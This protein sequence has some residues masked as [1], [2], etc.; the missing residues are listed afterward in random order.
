MSQPGE[1]REGSSK[2]GFP[3]KAAAKWAAGAIVVTAV[4]GGALAAAR[5]WP[6]NCQDKTLTSDNKEKPNALKA[7]EGRKGVDENGTPLKM[8]KAAMMKLAASE[9]ALP[10]DIRGD[11]VGEGQKLRDRDMAERE[12]RERDQL[13]GIERRP[14]FVNV[15]EPLM[16]DDYI[17]SPSRTAFVIMQSDGALALY[18]GSDPRDTN[19]R[20]Q[21]T[22]GPQVPSKGHPFFAMLGKDGNLCI[23]QG[24]ADAHGPSVWC[25]NSTRDNVVAVYGAVRFEVL[26]TVEMR[27]KG[28]R[29]S[30]PLWN[31]KHVVDMLEANQKMQTEAWIQSANKTKFM[32]LEPDGQLVIYAGNNPGA[33]DKRA[34]WKSGIVISG[35]NPKYAML[36]NESRLSIYEVM[37]PANKPVQRWSTTCTMRRPEGAEFIVPYMKL[38]NEGRLQIMSGTDEVWVSPLV[39]QDAAVVRG[40]ATAPL[41]GVKTPTIVAGGA[42]RGGVVGGI[43]KAVAPKSAKTIL[44]VRGAEKKTTTTTVKKI[45]PVVRGKSGGD[46]GSDKKVPQKPTVRFSK[47][48]VTKRGGG[49]GSSGGNKTVKKGIDKP[50]ITVPPTTRSTRGKSTKVI[51]AKRTPT[52]T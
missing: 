48:L 43:S 1:S 11:Y 38:T 49:S 16:E 12:R 51:A 7:A 20:M 10:D 45:V 22:T 36:D 3:W 32:R 9:G 18:E 15:G 29:S 14:F 39:S 35:S 8:K 42:V 52:S 4:V 41:S 28:N 13:A 30:V 27:I 37:P 5:V 47:E 2:H 33:T 34:M 6:F 31:T 19:A 25:S 24:S 40:G 21:Y 17:Q 50:M 26:D 44:T 23:Y 46:G